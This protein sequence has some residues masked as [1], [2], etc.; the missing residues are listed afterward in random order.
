MVQGGTPEMQGT[1]MD[2]R[3]AL[4]FA[5]WLSPKFEIW[6]YDTI[7]EILTE[8]LQSEKEKMFLWLADKIQNNAEEI[9]NLSDLIRS[10]NKKL[11]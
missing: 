6:I 7:Y 2:E 4:K 11:K 5:A 3:L 8:E 10:P 1:W 9:W